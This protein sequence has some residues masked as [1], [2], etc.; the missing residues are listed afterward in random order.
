M[1][2]LLRRQNAFTS[3]GKREHGLRRRRTAALYSKSSIMQSRHL[4]EVTNRIIHDRLRPELEALA[5][6]HGKADG[7]NLSYRICA[8]YLSSFVFGYSNGTD[9]LSEHKAEIDMWRV[10]YEN[11]A[12][13][14]SVY[15]QEMPSL[16][17]L[18]KRASIDLLPERYTAAKDF[19]TDWVTG[20]ASKADQAVDRERNLDLSSTRADEP[21]VYMAAKEA[22]KN[23]SPELSEE[24]AQKEVLS[25]MFDHVCTTFP[26]RL[27]GTNAFCP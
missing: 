4:Q 2:L 10:H 18:L 20:M 19:L 3:L 1:P 8:D 17:K 25:E 9:Y 11:S 12:P 13:H 22:V 21:V 6:V 23:D 7:L 16:Y 15:P 14:E 24:E 5:Q 27:S 26:L